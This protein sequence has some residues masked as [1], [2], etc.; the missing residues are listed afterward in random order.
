MDNF[1]SLSYHNYC[2]LWIY[3]THVPDDERTLEARL[4]YVFQLTDQCIQSVLIVIDLPAYILNSMP[5]FSYMS[6]ISCITTVLFSNNHII[7]SSSSSASLCGVGRWLKR[8]M[9]WPW[10]LP[11]GLF[12]AASVA[13]AAVVEHTFNVIHMCIY[14]FSFLLHISLSLFAMHI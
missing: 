13:Q 2:D 8:A 14:S 5:T 4:P 1:F 3:K 12:F 10:L 11:L 6:P 7:S 9:A